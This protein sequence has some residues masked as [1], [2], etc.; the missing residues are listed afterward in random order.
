MKPRLL[1]PLLFA[2][3]LVAAP[4]DEMARAGKALLDALTPEQRQKATFAFKSDERENWWFTPVD[5]KGLPLKEMTSAQ[6]HLAYALLTTGLSQEGV[7][8]ALTIMSLEQIL[9]DMEGPGRKFPRDPELYFVSIFGT[10]DAKGTWGW[11]VEGHHL[12]VNL[13]LVD[14]QLISGA[15]NFMGTN[16]AEVKTGQR[17]GVRVLAAEEDLGRELVKSLNTDQRKQAV[18]DTKAPDDILTGNQRVAQ[19]GETRGIGW[20]DLSQAQQAVLLKLISA[21]AGRL[22]GELSEADL[23]EIHDAGLANIRFAWA[24]GFE[25]G[26]RHYYRVHGPT[27]LIEYDNTQ[28]DANHVHAVWRDLKND[29][30]RDYLAEHLRQEHGK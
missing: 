16:P 9:Q 28:N 4:A 5:R 3:R 1:L 11:R 22:R 6:R 24:G 18:T 21:Y 15:P 29:F 2:L 19:A 8:K 17:A 12:S 23:A 20:S 14:G 27:F 13:T 30:G 25:R 7:Q 10:P 26:D